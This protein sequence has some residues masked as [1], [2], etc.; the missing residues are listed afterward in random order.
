MGEIAEAIYEGAQ[1]S[2]CGVCFQESHGYPVLCEDCHKDAPP[3][4][5]IQKATHP[6]F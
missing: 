2:E 5:R 1:C 6:E 4:N 3:G